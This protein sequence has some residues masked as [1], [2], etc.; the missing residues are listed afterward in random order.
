MMQ[1]HPAAPFLL[2][3]PF[4]SPTAL[5]IT[6]VMLAIFDRAG[7]EPHES[8]QMIQVTTGMVLGPA[9]HRSTYRAAWRGRPREAADRPATAQASG[10]GDFR[11]RSDIAG[12]RWN[13][14]T[15]ADAD[16]L[17]IE[18]LVSGLE[19]LARQPVVRPDATGQV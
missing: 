9:I 5:R 3:R 18:V 4:D 1:A 8:V 6:E 2:S 10:D 11:H 13:W 17:T 19:A 14:S 15:S 12:Q 16:R 7:F